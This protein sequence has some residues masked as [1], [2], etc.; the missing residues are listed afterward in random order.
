MTAKL[1][2]GCNLPKNMTHGCHG[3]KFLDVKDKCS[4]V[5][6]DFTPGCFIR[7]EK[8]ELKDPDDYYWYDPIV[9]ITRRLKA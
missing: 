4:N 5:R 1:V 7:A 9:H 6:P 3:C 8:L 2:R